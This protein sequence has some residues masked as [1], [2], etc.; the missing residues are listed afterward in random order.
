MLF[1]AENDY[2]NLV[3]ISFYIFQFLVMTL[4]LPENKLSEFLS[5]IQTFGSKRRATKQRLESLIGSVNLASK[6]IQ[7]GRLF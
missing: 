5:L 4:P 3:P 7:G 1:L 2:I 6:V